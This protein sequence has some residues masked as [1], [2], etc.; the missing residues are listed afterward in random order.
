[1]VR[2]GSAT[3]TKNP[4]KKPRIK[5]LIREFEVAISFDM[6]SPIGF[7]EIS[8]PQRKIERP[9]KRSP[10]PIRKRII[11]SLSISTKVKLKI[12]TNTTTGI[13]VRITSL[14]LASRRF[15]WPSSLR[16]H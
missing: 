8:I 14:V 15:I 11:M 7:I 6:Y 16:N 9:T 3:V 2:S 13:R 5:I 10:L 1:M 12:K 4:S